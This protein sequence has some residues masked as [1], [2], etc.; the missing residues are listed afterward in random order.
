MNKLK[1]L[2]FVI[3]I[4]GTFGFILYKNKKEIDANATVKEEVKNIPVSVAAASYKN[5]SESLTLIGTFEPHKDIKLVSEI[6]GKVVKVGVE[7]GQFVKPGQLIAQVD[8]EMIRA[9]LIAAEANFERAQKDVVRFENL[10]KG[11]AATDIQV[12]DANLRLKSA[13]S[14]LLTLRKQLRNTTIV[15]P[16]G[17]TVTTRS[18]ELGSVL[19]PGTALVEITDIS[20]LKLLVQVPEKEVVKYKEGGQI[21]VQADV[22]PGVTFSGKVTLVGVKADAAH[23]YPVEIMVAN[24]ASQPLRAGMYGRAA[25]GVAV[26]DSALAIP[27]AALI[28][29]VKNPQVYVVDNNK[30]VLKNIR[31]GADSQ[32]QVEVVSGLQAGEKVVVSGQI[33]LEN[34]SQ[35]SIVQ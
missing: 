16:I 10:R 30:A 5:L 18:F 14:Q 15:A 31:I 29:S 2:L 6:T 19:L 26:K 24:Q 3:A 7:E 34:N 33:N 25:T 12:E 4:A 21:N 20:K 32:G 1:T 35:V 28:G 23:N 17:G 11:N 27:R 8:N 22:Y 13:E 9:Q